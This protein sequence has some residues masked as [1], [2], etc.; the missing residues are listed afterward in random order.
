M[1][2]SEVRIYPDLVEASRA[3]AEAFVRIGE[4]SIAARGWFSVALSGG[5]TPNR[6]YADLALNEFSSRLD[7]RHAHFFWGDERSVPPDDPQSNF[8][9]ANDALLSHVQVPPENIHRIQA[10]KTPKEAASDYEHLLRGFEWGELTGF[11]LA[12]LGLG[13][14]GHTASLFPYS[15]ALNE[16]S[17]WCV[18]TW[19]EELKAARITLTPPFL[20]RSAN[21]IFLVVGSEKASIL[22]EILHGQYDPDRLP[23]Q[24]IEPKN[25]RLIWLV[26]RDAA[27]G[28][29]EKE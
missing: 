17:R 16:R 24:L 9:M 18:D 21:V 26:D 27:R 7:W 1:S 28:L 23:A 5:S 10:E 20:N 25:G 19:V 4:D 2:A 13:T 8:R 12:L 11:D 29:K 3:A 22:S 6:M 14:N 15:D